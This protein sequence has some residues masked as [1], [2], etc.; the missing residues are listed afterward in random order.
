M[1]SA[2]GAA[3]SAGIAASPHVFCS[4]TNTGQESYSWSP[5]ALQPADQRGHGCIWCGGQATV[6]V[7]LGRVAATHAAQCGNGTREYG[8]SGATNRGGREAPGTDHASHRGG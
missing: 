1:D 4:A 3:G 7:T 5:G 2:G 8:F 6:G